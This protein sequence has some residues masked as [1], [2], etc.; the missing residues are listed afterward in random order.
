GSSESSGL[1]AKKLTFHQVGWNTRAV[2]RQE[3]CARPL[4]LSVNRPR[5]QFLARAA[6]AVDQ[7]R[8]LTSCDLLNLA[9]QSIHGLALADQPHVGLAVLPRLNLR[10]LTV[11]IRLSQQPVDLEPQMVGR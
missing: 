9:S 10:Q 5:H 3:R 8:C 6:F 7:D 2:Y 11:H 1:M 4:A